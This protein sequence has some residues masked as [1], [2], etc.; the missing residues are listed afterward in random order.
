MPPY[1]VGCDFATVTQVRTMFGGHIRKGK[2]R[3]PISTGAVQAGIRGVNTT[4]AM[5]TGHQPL[6]QL[7]GIHY[8]KPIQHMLVGFNNFYLAME[9][10][11]TCHP[12]LLT[13]ACVWGHSK[14]MLVHQ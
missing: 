14:G 9:K 2:R 1:L 11:L 3:Q 4:I 7:D 10:K 13:C 5:D 12:D 8:V 6:T